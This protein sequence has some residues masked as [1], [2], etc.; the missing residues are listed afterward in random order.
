MTKRTHVPSDSEMVL[1]NGKTVPLRD[2]QN[3]KRTD[4]WVDIF[5]G[6]YR[7]FLNI[8][9]MTELERKCGYR[10]KEGNFRPRGIFEIF[11]SIARGR[12]ELDGKPVG[13]AAEGVATL[14][15]CRETVRQGLIGGGAAIVDGEH[16]RVDANRAREL[17]EAYLEPAPVEESWTLAFII[18]N[19]VVYGRE[20]RPDEEGTS[21]REAVYPTGDKL[22]PDAGEG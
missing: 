9:Q 20:Q 4:I 8:P 11:G 12:Y 5:D 7:L 10:D 17:L 18:L 14:L 16:V 1:P 6:T 15:D 19:T 21:S 2:T 13:F 3:T 22:N